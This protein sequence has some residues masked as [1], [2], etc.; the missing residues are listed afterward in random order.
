MILTREEDPKL[1]L[2]AL[3]ECLGNAPLAARRLLEDR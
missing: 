2:V 1:G 3:A